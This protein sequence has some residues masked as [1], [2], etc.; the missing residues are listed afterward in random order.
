MT[1]NPSP[2]PIRSIRYQTSLSAARMLPWLL[3]AVLLIFGL[4]LRLYDITDQPIDFHPTRQLRGAII[5]RGM[6]YEM[7][8]NADPAQRQLAID[9]WYST[10]QYEPSILEKLSAYTYLLLGSEQIWV[11][12][13]YSAVFWILGGIVLVDLARRLTG[14]RWAPALVA[15]AY[16]MVLPFGVQASRTIQPDP[17]MVMWIIFTFYALYRW[18]ESLT[19]QRPAPSWK[20]AV[21][22][23]LLG[24]IAILSKVVAAYPIAGAAVAVVLAALGWGR[25]WRNPQVWSMAMLMLLPSAYYY[26]SRG[27]RASEFFTSWTLSLAHLLAEPLVYARWFNLVQSLLGLAILMLALAGIAVSHAKARP[28]LLGM[29]VGYAAYGLFLPYQMYTHNYYHLM[30]VP[31]TALGLAPALA[32][33]LKRV[34][35][36]PLHWRL[37]IA[38]ILLVGIG[39]ASWNYLAEQ[40]Q[41]NYQTEVSHWQ[42]IASKIPAEGKTIA[43]TQ[44]YGY[45]LIYYGWRKVV[46]WP[47]VGERE[48]AN[49]RG[50]GKEFE[51]LFYNRT[52]GKNYFLITAFNQYERQPDLEQMLEENYPLLAEGQGYQIYDLDHPL[53]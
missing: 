23:G 42:E 46:L 47:I 45:R 39:Y 19:E 7:L 38:A 16:Y 31:M 25:F 50:R 13:A 52:E 18:S 15:L 35:H 10:G 29:W 14:G 4:A 5:A 36:Q 20:W 33:L 34:L 12:G 49:L 32:P 48:L 27:G 8:T 9:F 22:A 6:Y 3:A 30:L 44:D 1:S 2:P 41:Q 53:Q 21:S 40:M 51:D 43:L 26:L 28:L 24:G 37:G 17:M 11:P